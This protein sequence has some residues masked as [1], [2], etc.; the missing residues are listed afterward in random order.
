MDKNE[1]VRGFRGVGELS[2]VRRAH[3][4]Q[5]REGRGTSRDKEIGARSGVDIFGFR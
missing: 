5:C 4:Q 2:L 3:T 1:A